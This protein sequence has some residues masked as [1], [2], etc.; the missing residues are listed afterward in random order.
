MHGE[1]NCNVSTLQ[2]IIH[3][4]NECVRLTPHGGLA[5]DSPLLLSLG[6]A[7]LECVEYVVLEELLV[8]DSHFDGLP[9]WNMLLVPGL[10]Q[11]H[12]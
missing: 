8:G 10:H 5:G 4:N 3:Y 2:F 6:R 7:V 11:G 9:S 12:V 1:I